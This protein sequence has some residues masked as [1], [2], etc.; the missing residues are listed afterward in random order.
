MG[1]LDTIVKNV[2]KLK[3]DVSRKLH[4][5]SDTEIRKV[6]PIKMDEIDSEDTG[7]ISSNES[8]GSSIRSD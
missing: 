4:Q 7:I 8:V 6:A 3:S 1:S 2:I 5:V